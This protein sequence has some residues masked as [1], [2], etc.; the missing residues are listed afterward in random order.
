MLYGFDF[1]SHRFRLGSQR[2]EYCAGSAEPLQPVCFKVDE[3][4]SLPQPE[5]DSGSDDGVSDSGPDSAARLKASSAGGTLL[6][7]KSCYGLYHISDDG[8]QLNGPLSSWSW[9]L[10]HLLRITN[11]QAYFDTPPSSIALCPA[12]GRLVSFK[13]SYAARE[14][15]GAEDDYERTGSNEEQEEVEV[16][17][18]QLTLSIFDY[19]N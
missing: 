19:L 6:K 5:S 11:I 7:A 9:P 15:G 3:P 18:R 8:P 4:C 13:H 12:S 14:L 2:W 1:L 10:R 17:R 16:Q